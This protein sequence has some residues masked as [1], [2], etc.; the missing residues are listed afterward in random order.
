MVARKLKT[1][2]LI[3]FLISSSSICSG[4][5]RQDT[6]KIEVFAGFSTQK[7]ETEKFEEFALYAGL[8]PAQIQTNFNAS[9]VQLAQGFEDS[10]RAAPRLNGINAS[11]TYYLRGGL[12]LTGDFAY[13][14]K[15]GSHSTPNN[16]IFFEDFTCSRRRSFTVLGGPQ[17]KFRRQSRLQ[18]FVHLLA[19]FVKQDNRTGQ[20][21]N[22]SGG[23]APSIETRRLQDDFIAFTAGGG[24]GVDL[25]V[26]QHWAIRLLQ[27][28]YLASFPGS[29]GAALTA[30]A[31]SLGQ[32]NFD[33]FRR[34]GF[35]VSVGVV[36]R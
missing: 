15:T 23:S 25:N 31:T 22:S 4:Q 30:N 29:R 12:G 3:S 19:G 27:V 21:V 33:S 8:T 32:T 7:I 14:T 6:R 35:R 20:F 36:F 1:L 5:Q 2:L 10:Y 26:A 24:G 17:L 28:D 13:H 9:T 16:P 18:P 34:D 11:V